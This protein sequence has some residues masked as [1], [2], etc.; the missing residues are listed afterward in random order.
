MSAPTVPDR[1]AL[2]EPLRKSKLLLLVS[3]PVVPVME[4]LVSV[5]PGTVSELAPRLK[6][7]PET[8]TLPVSGS[9]SLAPKARVPSVMAVPPL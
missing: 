9:T 1:M 2:T 6:M 5:T 4:P 3:V 7:P 8:V